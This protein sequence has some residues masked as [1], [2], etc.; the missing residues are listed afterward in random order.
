MA[1]ES[2]NVTIASKPLTSTS[3]IQT[4]T[5]KPFQLEVFALNYLQN[6]EILT[7]FTRILKLNSCKTE[8]SLIYPLCNLIIELT[9]EEAVL[10]SKKYYFQK[11][12]TDTRQSNEKFMILLELV[13]DGSHGRQENQSKQVTIQDQVTSSIIIEDD[14]NN[15]S[16]SINN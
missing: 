8:P 13:E 10:T 3:E 15:Q 16:N 7:I 11:K 9:R 5:F 12:Q 4:D 6:Q 1:S 14:D 2:S